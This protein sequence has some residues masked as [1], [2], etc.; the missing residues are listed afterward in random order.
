MAT[1]PSALPSEPAPVSPAKGLIDVFFAPG[2]L[3]ERLRTRPHWLLPLLV[4]AVVM[5]VLQLLQI[6]YM[7]A[8]IRATIR[9]NASIPADQMQKT[10][11]M[12]PMEAKIAAAVAP[13]GYVVVMLVM[14]LV[15]WALTLMSGGK[16]NF[17]TIFAGYTYTGLIMLPSMILTFVIVKLRGGPETIQSAMDLQWTIGPASFFTPE[18]HKL[19]ALFNYCN[20]FAL[21]SLVVT[22][23]MVEKLALIKR[24]SAIVC[25]LVPWLAGLGLAIAFAK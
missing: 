22:V 23:I 15:L 18:S 21:W 2:E 13:L 4:S 5:L 25:S 9:A 3:F 16:A 19:L 6:P 11:S 17:K 20:L 24:T 14:A 1:T 8:V 12:V 7:E 10:L